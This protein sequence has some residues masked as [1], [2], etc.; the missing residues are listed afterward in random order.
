MCTYIIRV[1]SVLGLCGVELS[2]LQFF[3]VQLMTKDAYN[4][5]YIFDIHDIKI[6]NQI[7]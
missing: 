1:L 4:G 6:A 7:S 3:R 2:F 5:F